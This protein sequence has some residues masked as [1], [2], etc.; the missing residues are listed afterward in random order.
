[1]KY[2][3]L[4]GMESDILSGMMSEDQDVAYQGLKLE[5]EFAS[6]EYRDGIG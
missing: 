2:E 1:M 6:N 5:C 3:T 4:S